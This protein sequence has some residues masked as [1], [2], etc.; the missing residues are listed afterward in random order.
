[1]VAQWVKRL[2][3]K[4]GDLSSIPRNSRKVERETGPEGKLSSDLHM[5]GLF[6][7]TWRSDS[8]R[9]QRPV[10]TCSTFSASVWE[11]RLTVPFRTGVS[12]CG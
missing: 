1:M 9:L 7:E 12:L 3:A 2:V 11:A 4:P 6:S 5:C 10:R 8:A